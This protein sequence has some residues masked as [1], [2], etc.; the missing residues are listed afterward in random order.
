[1]SPVGAEPTGDTNKEDIEQLN[2]EPILNTTS[3][4]RVKREVELN[5]D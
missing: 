5:S 4:A 1:M 3:N 2:P